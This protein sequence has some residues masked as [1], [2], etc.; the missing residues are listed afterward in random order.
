MRSNVPTKTNEPS[1]CDVNVVSSSQLTDCRLFRGP[2]RVYRR[3]GS[4]PFLCSNSSISSSST[5]KINEKGKFLNRQYNKNANAHDQRLQL[6]SVT[7]ATMTTHHMLT[8]TTTTTTTTATYVRP[9]SFSMKSDRH[10][11]G[12]VSGLPIMIHR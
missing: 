7:T 3:H 1:R 12:W 4:D 10:T 9:I 6:T 8:T 2:I 5:I 11:A